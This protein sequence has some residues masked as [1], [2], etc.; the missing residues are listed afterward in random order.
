MI[1]YFKIKE[2]DS[3]DDIR[4]L[5]DSIGKPC[6]RNVQ[7]TQGHSEREAKISLKLQVCSSSSQP[8]LI[9]FF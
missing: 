5:T 2:D 3:Q 8:S 1:F 7:A 6:S 4:L 9:S